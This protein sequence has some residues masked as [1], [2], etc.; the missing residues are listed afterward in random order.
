MEVC[1][2][3]LPQGTSCCRSCRALSLLCKSGKPWL[4]PSA[5]HDEVCYMIDCP[6]EELI[7]H[8]CRPSLLC[9]LFPS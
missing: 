9:P 2:V 3:L 7:I 1:N 5:M 8:D 4:L 6:K